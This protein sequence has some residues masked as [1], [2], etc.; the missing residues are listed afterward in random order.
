MFYLEQ[1]TYSTV[2]Y[3]TVQYSTVQYSTLHVMSCQRQ[4]GVMEIGV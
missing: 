2:Q 3:S 4:V 1:H